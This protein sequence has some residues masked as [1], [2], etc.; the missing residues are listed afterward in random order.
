[1]HNA[2]NLKWFP[3]IYFSSQWNQ[4]NARVYQVICNMLSSNFAITGNPWSGIANGT[5][6]SRSLLIHRE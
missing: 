3:A 5:F 6:V 4:K 1:M 2:I